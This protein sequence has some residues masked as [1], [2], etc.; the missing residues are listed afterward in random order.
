MPQELPDK[1]IL[2]FRKRL[3][4]RVTAAGGHFEPQFKY[5]EGSWHSLL[6]RLKCS[7]KSCAKF[8]SLLRKTYSIFRTR[9]HVHLKKWTLKFKQLYLLNRICYFNKICRICI[10]CKSGKYNCYNF[11][12]MKFFLGGTFFGAPCIVVNTYKLEAHTMSMLHE[13]IDET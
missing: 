4:F 9:L 10:L 12:D 13:T 1:A 8:D 5:R 6:N 3:R 2:L 7:R 11:R